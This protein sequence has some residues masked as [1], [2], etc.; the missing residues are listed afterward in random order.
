MTDNRSTGSSTDIPLE[1][2]MSGAPA[3]ELAEQLVEQAR[4]EGVDLVGPGG[5]LGDL[6]K[7]VLEAG[8]EAEMTDH[9]R[10]ARPRRP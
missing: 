10:Q 6:T 1:L 4:A 9:L 7:R 5:L 8:L 3:V 2:P